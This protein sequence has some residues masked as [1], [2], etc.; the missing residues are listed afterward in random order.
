MRLDR[1]VPPSTFSTTS[2]RVSSASRAVAPPCLR[3]LRRHEDRAFHDARSAEADLRLAL[4]RVGRVLPAARP[5]TKPLTSLSPPRVRR[6]RDDL[7]APIARGR[8]DCIHRVRVNDARLVQSETPFIERRS[9]P[10]LDVNRFDAIVASIPRLCRRGPML[11]RPFAPR[12][13]AAAFAPAFCRGSLVPGHATVALLLRGARARASRDEGA[14]IRLLQ[15]LLSTRG[16]TRRTNRPRPSCGV[17]FRMRCRV[18]SLRKRAAASRA[19]HRRALTRRA[20]L[21]ARI[22]WAERPE[23]R[24]R[25]MASAPPR[26][27]ALEHPSHRFDDSEGLEK[28]SASRTGRRSQSSAAPRRATPSMR[29]RC[30]PPLRN[31]STRSRL[32][33]HAHARTVSLFTPPIRAYA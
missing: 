32:A 9:C 4:L 18:V 12:G 29:S 5:K 1:L 14:A 16:H 6:C 2:T 22:V 24:A 10:R 19:I 8:R 31:P 33:P 13:F 26:S 27:D 21:E 3:E 15:P 23:R 28:P 7:P 30:F 17:D 25:A 20:P 11:R